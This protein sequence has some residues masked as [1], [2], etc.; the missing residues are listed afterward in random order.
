MSMVW[1]HCSGGT[2]RLFPVVPLWFPLADA[3]PLRP[4]ALLSVLSVLRFRR[5]SSSSRFCLQ[6]SAAPPY[7]HVLRLSS[8]LAHGDAVCTN[9]KAAA[10]GEE[11]LEHVPRPPQNPEAAT[12]HSTPTQPLMAVAC[13]RTSA[14]LRPTTTY[15]A[16]KGHRCRSWRPQEVEQRAPNLQL[17]GL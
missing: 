14:L 11:A 10:G 9:P 7:R 3:A 2:Y 5:R 15:S 17:R 13:R 6:R 1:F 4:C 12:S 16:H 8:F